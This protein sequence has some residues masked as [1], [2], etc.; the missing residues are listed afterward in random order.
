MFAA[1]PRS[2][3]AVHDAVTVLA[4]VLIVVGCCASTDV[5]LPAERSDD[6]TVSTVITVVDNEMM[7][8]HMMPESDEEYAERS[9]AIA[10]DAEHAEAV[11]E[12]D[13]DITAAEARYGVDLVPS[14][15]PQES[16]LGMLTE[17]TEETLDAN[18]AYMA[19]IDRIDAETG[20][21]PGVPQPGVLSDSEHS[22]VDVDAGDFD[23]QNPVAAPVAVEP[24]GIG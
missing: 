8:T 7:M 12:T 21:Q 24:G 10:E 15:P 13:L 3:S 5:D 23:A 9:A 16:A 22:P 14:I 19:E 2:R 11:L 1:W 20:Y 17:V 6:T 4:A 18:Q